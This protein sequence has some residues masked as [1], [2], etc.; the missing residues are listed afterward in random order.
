KVDLN[1]ALRG[2]PRECLRVLPGDIL[3][4]QE[5]PSEALA[6]Y[7]SQ[8]FFNFRLS[9]QVLHESFATGVIDVAAPE[10]IPARIGI[11]NFTGFP[12]QYPPFKQGDKET[13]EDGQASS[14]ATRPYRLVPLS[15]GRGPSPDNAENAPQVLRGRGGP[16]G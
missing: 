8:T 10:R 4:L 5:K 11:T 12:G 6:R 15:P 3:I 16:P 9:W 2:D 7:F 13:M 1:R 14:L